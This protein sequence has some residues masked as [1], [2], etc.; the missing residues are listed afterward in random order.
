MGDFAE[1]EGRSECR[2]CGHKLENEHRNSGTCDGCWY[3]MKLVPKDWCAALKK[4]GREPRVVNGFWVPAPEKE[5][6]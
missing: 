1:H 4:R 3:G 5:R 6:V 2:W